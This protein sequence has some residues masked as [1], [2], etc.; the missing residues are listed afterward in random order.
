M[1]TYVYTRSV[2]LVALAIFALAGCPDSVP[3]EGWP[4]AVDASDF[5]PP[6]RCEQCCSTELLHRVSDTHERPAYCDKLA[7]ECAPAPEAP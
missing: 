5:E 3:A 2:L 6:H 1:S 7:C 4:I